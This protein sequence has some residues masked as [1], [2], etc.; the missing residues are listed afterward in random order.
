[1]TTPTDEQLATLAA[2]GDIAARNAFIERHMGLIRFHCAKCCN[3]DIEGYLSDAVVYVCHQLAVYKGTCSAKTAAFNFLP[4]WL[5]RT[6]RYESRTI[7]GPRT[8]GGKTKTPGRYANEVEQTRYTF[9]L[10]GTVHNSFRSELYASLVPDREPYREG[11]FPD[12]RRWLSEVL[13]MLNDKSRRVVMGRMEGRTL[14]EIG[15]EL[16][17]TREW[18]RKIQIEAMDIIKAM[19]EESFPE[20]K[21]A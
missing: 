5:Y 8:S 10:S 7:T 14:E 11:P 18:V 3:G 19:A 4:Q 15:Q 16:G 20:R 21:S 12:R 2:N 17:V 1:M 13:G 6:R 9:S